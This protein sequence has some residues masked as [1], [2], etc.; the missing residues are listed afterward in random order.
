MLNPPVSFFTSACL[1]PILCQGMSINYVK[2][3][4]GGGG[5]SGN[6]CIYISKLSCIVSTLVN[7]CFC[8][9]FFVFMLHILNNLMI[10]NKFQI[11][12]SWSEVGKYWKEKS[13]PNSYGQRGGG[14][15]KSQTPRVLCGLPL[16]MYF[17]AYKK[18][19]SLIFFRQIVDIIL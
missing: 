3:W 16:S 19:I 18:Y 10:L 7:N 8:C 17:I 9:R 1:C 15:K 14:D 6:I 4:M 5:V 12:H 11:S 2:C 13:H